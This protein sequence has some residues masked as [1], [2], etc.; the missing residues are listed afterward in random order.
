MKIKVKNII[1][2]IAAVGVMILMVFSAIPNVAFAAD[3]A[4][5]LETVKALGIT[6]GENLGSSVTR[7][8][9]AKMLVSASTFKDEVGTDS[10]NSLY[11]DV[12]KDHWAVEYIKIAVEQGWMTGYSDGTFRPSNTIRYEEAATAVLK[13][14]GYDPSTFA[15]NFPSAQIS[16]F[17]SLSLADGTSLKKGTTLT[18]NDCVNIFYNLMNADDVNGA[19]YATK[20]GYTVTSTGE[21]SYSS[22]VSNDLKGPYVY[23]SGD[24]FA[25][26][27]FSSADAAIYRNGV[28]TTLAS[29]QIY[30]VY[31]YNTTLKTVWLYANSVTGTFTAAQPSTSAPTSATVAGN[32]YTLESAAAYKLSDLG[33][34]TIGDK[35]TLLLGKDGTAV[36]VISTSRFSGSFTGVITKIGTDSYTNE[37]GA[38]IIEKVLYV[39]CTDGVQRTYSAKTDDFEV[40]QTVSV[41]FNGQTSSVTRASGRSLTGAF[42][43]DGTKL[44]SM[45][46]AKGC[47]IININQDGSVT[48]TYVSKLAGKN[49]SS[50]DVRYYITNGNNEITDLIL[51]DVLNEGKQFGVIVDTDKIITGYDNDGEETCQITYKYLINGVPGEATF[52]G[53]DYGASRGPAYFQFNNGK[54][55]Y[56]GR[57]SGTSLTNVG[58]GTASSQTQKYNLSED[59]Q[60]YVKTGVESYEMTNINTASNT[61]QY[62]VTG[63]VYGNEVVVIVL[64]P[65]S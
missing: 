45:T 2:K 41:S 56:I 37:A 40:G 19:K 6:T 29:A 59:V 43:S 10:A 61:D 14:L 50:G 7:A 9:F 35:V 36:D 22:L 13:L 60:V 23:E 51:Y 62:T 52:T 31:Y 30:D 20:L 58:Y 8:E 33:T 25:N 39:T 24:L 1:S 46:I 17:E 11:K 64:V 42:N 47:N 21:I 15:G 55:V 57:L 44:G 38:K 12:K 34:Y 32:T 4:T 5:A 63:Y 48:K 26:I 27:P 65:R 53:D 16:K 54:L 18:R 28:S 49:M 3:S